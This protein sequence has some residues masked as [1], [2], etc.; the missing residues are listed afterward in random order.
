MRAAGTLQVG[1]QGSR[2]VKGD[3]E[4]RRSAGFPAMSGLNLRGVGGV[5]GIYTF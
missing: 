1:S 2:G 5:L 3:E 4:E